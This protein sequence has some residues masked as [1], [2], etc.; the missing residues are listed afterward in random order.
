M[1]KPSLLPIRYVREGNV[2]D[3]GKQNGA[4]QMEE[5]DSGD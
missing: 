4:K 1:T 2:A 3:M 5:E